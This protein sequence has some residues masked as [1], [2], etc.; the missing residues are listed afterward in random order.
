MITPVIVD[1]TSFHYMSIIE[2]R[3]N[4]TYLLR[5]IRKERKKHHKRYFRNEETSTL[6]DQEE[7][8]INTIIN[9]ENAIA[10]ECNSLEQ[11]VDSLKQWGQT[12]SSFQMEPLNQVIDLKFNYI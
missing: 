7:Q 8:L 10:V 5:E 4:H 2:I 1:R 11:Q 3:S 6:P 9:E 12:V